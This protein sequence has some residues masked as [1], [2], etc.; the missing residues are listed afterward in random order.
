VPDVVGVAL[1]QVEALSAVADIGV[2]EAVSEVETTFAPVAAPQVLRTAQVVALPQTRVVDGPV[3]PEVDEAEG[4]VA[5]TEAV[6]T[7]PASDN[8]ALERTI[9]EERIS[10]LRNAIEPIG[11]ED[12][13]VV[14]PTPLQHLSVV[15][16]VGTE[17]TRANPA[18]GANYPTWS[19]N[20]DTVAVVE[21]KSL[22]EPVT[23]GSTSTDPAH[24]EPAAPL[25]TL[26]ASIGLS[27]TAAAG[28][29]PSFAQLTVG[30]TWRPYSH[31]ARGC[32]AVIVLPNLA[33]PG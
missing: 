21:D 20:P 25:S 14:E 7:I 33:P 13:S 3:P 30:N 11:V 22:V 18:V 31:T 32:Q 1:D 16:A 23:N 29:L 15:E 27:T 26:P 2:D 17:V 9:V 10:V 8:W 19:W 28:W 12:L 6:P 24:P 5:A 4:V